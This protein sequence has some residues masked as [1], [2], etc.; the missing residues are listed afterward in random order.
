VFR[1]DS[2]SDVVKLVGEEVEGEAVLAGTHYHSFLL[3]SVVVDGD[4]TQ[5]LRQFEFLLYLPSHHPHQQLLPHSHAHQRELEGSV[6]L[7]RDPHLTRVRVYHLHQGSLLEQCQLALTQH[8][9]LTADE[10]YQGWGLL[11]E[12]NAEYRGTWVFEGVKL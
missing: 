5:W 10:R 6:L 4:T 11:S 8:V 1:N 3:L 7:R 12:G 9:H 2:I